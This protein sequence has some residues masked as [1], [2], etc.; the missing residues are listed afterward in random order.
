MLRKLQNLLIV[1][2]LLC[3]S[4]WMFRK[5]DFAPALEVSVAQ[6]AVFDQH[7]TAFEKIVL[8]SNAS[9][10]T[11]AAIISAIQADRN[12]F[13][14]FHSALQSFLATA[15]DIDAEKLVEIA[16]KIYDKFRDK[17]SDK[18]GIN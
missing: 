1:P 2:V 7:S 5:T 6:K 4:C 12:D 16:I 11:K 9:D 10:Q 8:Q 3:S 18:V 17:I 13:Y 14:M 15:G